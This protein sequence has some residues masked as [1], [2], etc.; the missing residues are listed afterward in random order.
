MGA[1]P[2]FDKFPQKSIFE[3]RG[4]RFLK[5]RIMQINKI[6]FAEIRGKAVALA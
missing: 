3:F 5:R 2:E 4:K 1:R 6:E